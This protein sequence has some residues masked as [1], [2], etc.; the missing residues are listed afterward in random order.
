MSIQREGTKLVISAKIHNSGSAA[1]TLEQIGSQVSP[2]I[3][4]SLPV[5]AGGTVTLGRAGTAA[6]LDQ[7][8][9][10]EPGGTV[11]LSFDFKNGGLLQVF[12][13]FR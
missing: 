7:Q 1:D 10:L 3:S 5:P 13:T 9:R 6:V 4:F 11:D 8:G 12:S 2:T